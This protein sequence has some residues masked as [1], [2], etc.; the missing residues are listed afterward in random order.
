VI[1]PDQHFQ[2]WDYDQ[3]QKSRGGAVYI[4]VEPDG[5]VTIHKG[6]A[7]RAAACRALS[8]G[9]N[10]AAL[11]EAVPSERPEMSA[12]LANA[13]DLLRHSV[14]R[15]ALANAPKIALR[16]VVAHMVG[17]SPLW[18]LEAERQTPHSDAIATWRETLPTQAAFAT[19]R[20]EAATRLGAEDGAL[21]DSRAGG[22]CT[23][24]VFALLQAWSDDDVLALLAVVM[25][26]TLAMG[27][28]LID[29]L[30]QVLGVDVGQHW[31]PDAVFFELAKDR[32]A[33]SGMLAE[34]IGDRSAN[35]Y[36]TETGP[37]KKAIIRKA[38]A[39]DGR[40]KV[41][42]WLPRYLRFP[43]AGYTAR[44]LSAARTG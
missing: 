38:L 8:H 24:Q 12:P 13:V 30:G 4:D 22:A 19:L 44:P 6:L 32:E 37:K 18:R 9:H 21:I 29:Q 16:L 31:Q 17:G 23:A 40:T 14:V 34:V 33:V 41:D 11:S 15:L 43:Q 20:A 27:T 7:P 39:G 26:E 3:V 10:G 5:H 36:L 25:A 1:A 35:S 42:G 2:A 28:G